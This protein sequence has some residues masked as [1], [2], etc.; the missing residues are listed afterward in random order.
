[1]SAIAFLPVGSHALVLQE[2]LCRYIVCI[3][4]SLVVGFAVNIYCV[5]RDCHRGM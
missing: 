5:R 3:Y 1:M 4:H 2:V